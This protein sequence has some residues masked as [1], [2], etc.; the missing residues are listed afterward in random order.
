MPSGGASAVLRYSRGATNAK[1]LPASAT[2]WYCAERPDTWTQFEGF[3]DGRY[4][5]V[6]MVVPFYWYA[7]YRTEEN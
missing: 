4:R 1:L 6:T 5:R 3:A 7:A 2:T